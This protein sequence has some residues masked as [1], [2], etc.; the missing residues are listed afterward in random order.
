[1]LHSDQAGTGILFVKLPFRYVT[2]LDL[3]GG[4]VLLLKRFLI[5]LRFQEA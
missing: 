4:G 2:L 1:M 5:F 3:A